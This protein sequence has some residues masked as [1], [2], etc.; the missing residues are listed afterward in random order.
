[1]QGCG[2]GK[3]EKEAAK[4]VGPVGEGGASDPRG[5]GQ[6]W[7]EGEASAAHQQEPGRRAGLAGR[8][9][10]PG[11]CSQRGDRQSQQEGVQAAA[12]ALRTTQLHGRV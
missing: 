3:V 4:G 1:M 11:H 6:A 9:V 2:R 12:Q 10:T 7:G 5:R 8:T